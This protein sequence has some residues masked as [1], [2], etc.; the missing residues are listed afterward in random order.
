MQIFYYNINFVL[1][2]Y[3]ICGKNRRE[4]IKKQPT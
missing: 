1:L 3:K 4:I 2:T